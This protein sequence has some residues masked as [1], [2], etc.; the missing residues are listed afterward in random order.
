VGRLLEAS[1][2]DARSIYPGVIL[3]PCT[4]SSERSVAHSQ[5]IFF[6]QSRNTSVYTL[7]T[8]SQAI[9][10]EN[11]DEHYSEKYYQSLQ[12]FFQGNIKML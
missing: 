3:A 8:F 7:A 11:H 10:E 12:P 9:V 5:S 2:S 1:V 6:R 4:H